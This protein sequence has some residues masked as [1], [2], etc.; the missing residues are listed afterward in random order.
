MESMWGCVAA[1]TEKLKQCNP[2][3]YGQPEL[4]L[5]RFK[6]QGIWD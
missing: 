3:Q 6:S 4:P 2:M 1:A 5:I